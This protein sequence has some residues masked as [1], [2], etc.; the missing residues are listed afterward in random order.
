MYQQ[1]E[2]T[3]VLEGNKNLKTTQNVDINI[4]K[5]ADKYAIDVDSLESFNESKITKVVQKR[6]E[7]ET[8]RKLDINLSDIINMVIATS[9]RPMFL[10]RDDKVHTPLVKVLRQ[11]RWFSQSWKRLQRADWW[12]ADRDLEQHIPRWRRTTSEK[13]EFGFFLIM[14]KVK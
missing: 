4:L 14:P 3:N 10:I 7:E 8:W 12:S 6:K 1:K 13:A 5:E 2:I 9:E 11:D